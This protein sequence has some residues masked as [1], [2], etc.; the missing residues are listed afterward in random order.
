M[1]LPNNA[2]GISD[3]LQFRDCRRKFIF[4]MRRHLEGGDPPEDVHPDTMY[5]KAVHDGITWIEED[6]LTD[7][8]AVDRCFEVYGHWLEPEDADRLLADFETY[9]NRDESGVVTVANETEIRVPLLKWCYGCS[10]EPEEDE[11]DTCI[12][13]GGKVET[14]YFRARI[15]RL[16]QNVQNP[17]IFVHRDYKSSKWR[18]SEEEVHGD[19]QM[20]SYN[21]AIHR[22]WTECADLTQWYDQL[23]YGDIPTRKT[24]E[25]RQQMWEW[26]KRQVRA[27][28]AETDASPTHNEWCPWCPIME[29]CSEVKRLSEWAIARIEE[30]S[31]NSGKL[32]PE[33]LVGKD[34]EEYVADLP[35]IERARKMAERYEDSVRG[36]LKKL[37]D[38]RLDELEYRKSERSSNYWTPEALRATLDL[39]GEEKF[40]LMVGLTKTRVEKLL[41]GEEKQAVLDMATKAAGAMTVTKKKG[42]G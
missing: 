17:A 5:G 27:I 8:E 13:C 2:V 41:D 24:A 9:R 42:S 29:S 7:E 19:K 28:L 25:Q 30:L 1:R 36:E 14:I 18:K 37:P 10:R 16:Y 34:F 15:D 6:M 33:L 12:G 23:R 22:Y 20:W 35:I 11:R 3:I 26:L 39:V 21:C 32:E 4:Q 40:L 38:T 31:P